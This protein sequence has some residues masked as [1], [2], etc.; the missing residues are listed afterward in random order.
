MSGNGC[1]CPAGTRSCLAGVP[2]GRAHVVWYM[3]FVPKNVLEKLSDCR[4]A[5][6]TRGRVDA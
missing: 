2:L 6:G 4:V 3:A 1:G 5:R